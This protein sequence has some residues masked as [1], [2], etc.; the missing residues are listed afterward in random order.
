MAKTEYGLNHPMAVKVWTRKLE[1]EML[2]E[3]FIGKIMGGSDSIVQVKDELAKGPGDRITIGLRMQL[4]GA[5]I[6]GDSTLEGFEEALSVYHDNVF[7][8]QLRHAVRS[9]GKMSEQRVPFDVRNEAMMGLTDWW[10]DR[11]DTSFINQVCGNTA[12]TDTR[13]TGNQAAIAASTTAG[14]ARIIYGPLD[15]TTENSLSASESGS[16]DFRLT[17]IDK[18]ITTARTATPYLRPANTPWGRKFVCMLHPHQVYDLRTDA[19]AGRVTW[20]NANIAKVQGGDMNNY[21]FTGGTVLGEYNGTVLVESTRI[22]LAPSTTTVRRGVF[23]GAQAAALA[24][25]KDGG[26]AKMN[27]YE[28]LYDYGNSLGVKCGGIFGLKKLQFNGND[29]G[30]IVL[31]SHAEAP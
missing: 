13:Y 28:E 5:G 20:Y 9:A 7:I 3:T 23:L 17:M 21:I 22:P 18:A 15:A 27:W 1:H 11:L 19:T 6:Q 25:G 24:W 10:A 8:D 16:A 31:A 14:N 12:Q 26:E 30:S 29:F 2:K 4:A